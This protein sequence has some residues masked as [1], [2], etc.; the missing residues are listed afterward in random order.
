VS[1][2]HSLYAADPDDWVSEDPDPYGELE[3]AAKLILGSIGVVDYEPPFEDTP[4]RF[5]RAFLELCR[6]HWEDPPELRAFEYVGPAQ[7]ITSY[8]NQAYCLC[9]HHLLSV[10]LICSVGYVVSAGTTILPS[11]ILGLSK[12]PRLIAWAA[13]RLTT[14]EDL[15][16]LI[17]G[18]LTSTL[19]SDTEIH[20]HIKGTHS[21][22]RA[23]G[24]KTNGTVDTFL[25]T[26]PASMW[27][28]QFRPSMGS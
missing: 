27:L 20:I 2:D 23:R 18:K 22:M 3:D 9:P 7:L 5:A 26:H 1:E 28:R 10:E 25:T 17:Q 4:A 21:C 15:A 8:D 24:I 6:G 14:Q 13:S 12:L 16:V 19:G 11:R